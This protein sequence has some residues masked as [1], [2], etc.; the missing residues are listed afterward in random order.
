[1][2]FVRNVPVVIEPGVGAIEA[3]FAVS[4][5]PK[6]PRSFPVQLMRVALDS[7]VSQK[8][9]FIP[10]TKLPHVFSLTADP[11]ESVALI[12]Y[13]NL[14]R[15]TFVYSRDDTGKTWEK[16]EVS[17]E[18]AGKTVTQFSVRFSFHSA[19]LR[20]KFMELVD[21]VM[22]QIQQDQKPNMA[23][24]EAVFTIL[25]RSRVNPVVMPVAVAKSSLKSIKI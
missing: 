8:L 17:T 12:V 4:E 23:D 1:M 24:V 22:A 16:R 14:G 11:D 9:P 3:E 2:F 6:K 20:D 21:T 10:S 19:K 15:I 5:P 7:D 13:D 25:S 18:H